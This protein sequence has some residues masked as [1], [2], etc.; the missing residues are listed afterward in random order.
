MYKRQ[1]YSLASRLPC[2]TI[3]PLGLLVEPEVYCRKASDSGVRVG[4]V[5]AAASPWPGRS[6]ARHGMSVKPASVNQALMPGSLALSVRTAL[7]SA[8]RRMPETRAKW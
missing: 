3:T 1:A 5:Q 6:V 8:S 4:S 7:T 2:E